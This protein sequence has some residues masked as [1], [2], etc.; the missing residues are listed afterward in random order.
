MDSDKKSSEQP[1]IW[2]VLF[3]GLAEAVKMLFSIIMAIVVAGSKTTD[4]KTSSTDSEDHNS[5]FRNGHSGP[6]YYD[7]NDQKLKHFDDE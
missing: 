4:S 2:T 6:G 1:D 5:G 7:S 3:N